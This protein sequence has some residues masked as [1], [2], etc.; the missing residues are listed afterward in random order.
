M[1]LGAARGSRPASGALM[2]IGVAALIIAMGVDLPDASATGSLPQSIA[3]D[4]ARAQ[5]A[6][7]FFLET[8]AGA[9]LLAAGAALSVLSGR[10][11]REAAAG[12]ESERRR[13]EDSLWDPAPGGGRSAA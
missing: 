10:S 1:S 3:Y 5:P 13:A 6:V 2:V 11:R 8:S 9:A 4:D 12:R 7:G